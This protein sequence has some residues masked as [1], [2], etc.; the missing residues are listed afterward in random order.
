MLVLGKWQKLGLLGLIVFFVVLFLVY[1]FFPVFFGKK[2]A[3]PACDLRSS[4]CAPVEV[5]GAK[6]VK[7]SGFENL[8]KLELNVVIENSG[9]NVSNF[10]IEKQ[11]F[12]LKVKISNKDSE[13][14]RI[15][16]LGKTEKN[17]E[18][19]ET[20]E[21]ERIIAPN[22]STEILIISPGKLDTEGKFSK[23]ENDMLLSCTTCKSNPRLDITIKK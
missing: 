5:G 1:V 19:F 13:S 3:M 14:H 11:S 22:E 16:L 4:E 9:F 20:I 10:L 8:E 7:L 15:A 6:V 17:S 23:Y 21:R 2:Q 12:S 18:I